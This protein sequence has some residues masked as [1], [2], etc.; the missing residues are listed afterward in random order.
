MNHILADD[1]KLFEKM[2]WENPLGNI[3]GSQYS[4]GIFTESDLSLLVFKTL[5]Y[6][7]FLFNFCSDCVN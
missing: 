7:S 4:F 3:I 5:T 2:I 6:D 1:L